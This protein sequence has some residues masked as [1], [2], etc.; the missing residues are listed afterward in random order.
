MEKHKIINRL[1]LETDYSRFKDAD[2]VV[3]AVFEDLD[4]KKKVIQELEEVIPDHCVI[5]T[6]TSALSIAEIAESSKNPSRV[7]GMHYFSPVEQMQLLEVVKGPKTSEESLKAAVSVG[8]KQGKM[9]IV[10]KCQKI[11]KTH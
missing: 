5:G 2:I 1:N 6:N 8:L 3:E 10:A 4:L 9:V 11:L 7:V